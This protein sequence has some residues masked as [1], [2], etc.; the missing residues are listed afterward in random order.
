MPRYPK[1]PMEFVIEGL[2]TG[3]REHSTPAG[4]DDFTGRPIARPAIP[5]RMGSA[6]LLTPSEI[7]ALDRQRHADKLMKAH[8][9]RQALARAVQSVVQ[10]MID[11]PKHRPFRRRF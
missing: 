5:P 2:S 11:P 6:P 7:I 10:R 3:E 4:V 8:K 9:Q 1:P